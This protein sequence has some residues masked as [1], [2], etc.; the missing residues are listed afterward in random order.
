MRRREFISLL[1]GSVVVLPLVASAQQGSSERVI[2]VLSPISEDAAFR[3][4]EALRAGL[5]DL[6]Y[7]KAAMSNLK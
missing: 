7:L 6:G 1:G 3:N 4:V 2:G 5:R